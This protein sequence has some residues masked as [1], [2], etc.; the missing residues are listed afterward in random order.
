MNYIQ[1]EEGNVK[2]I[3]STISKLIQNKK[4]NYSK[5]RE[6]LKN[7]PLT[8]NCYD[9]LTDE[10]NG[11]V[12]ELL[13]PI[14]PKGDKIGLLKENS[15]QGQKILIVMLW[16]CELS[17]KENKKLHPYNID[18][19]NAE[20]SKCISNTVSYLGV[21]VKKVLNYIEAINEITK[22]DKNG[23][24]NYYAVWVLCGPNINKLPD[25]SNYPGLVEQFIDCLILYWENGGAVGLFCDNDPLYFQ[26][27]MFLEKVRFKGQNGK[28]EKTKLR[29]TGDDPGKNVLIGYNANGNLTKNSSYDTS[30]IRLPNGTE[31]M[32][33]GRNVP[34]IYEGDSISHA[35]SNNKE[36][37]KPF[38]PF[39]KNSSGNI[40][41]MLYC[42]QGR[43]GDIIIDCGYTKAFFKMSSGDI[44]TWRYF[45]NIA[46]FLSRPEAHM[47]YD[48]GETAKNYRPNG[49]NFKID[50]SNLY[51]KFDEYYGFGSKSTFSILILD[52][53][54]SM[55]SYYGDLIDMTNNIIDNQKKNNKNGIR[56]I[57]FATN[58]KTVNYNL[59]SMSTDDIKNANVGGGT[60]FYKGFQEAAKYI[61]YGKKFDSRRVLFL[62]DGEDDDYYR[63]DDICSTMKYSGYKIYIMGFGAGSLFENLRQFASPDCFDTR[64]VFEDV[65]QICIQAFSS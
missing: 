19:T 30:I 39:A 59:Y 17:E 23:R 2:N 47:I 51:T 26:T 49:I 52:V 34:Q 28:L 1:K 10:Q 43:E 65:K 58:A 24:C 53:S 41:I 6:E 33:L 13:R 3:F 9:M 60:N 29:I 37:I 8:T 4:Y 5:L 7:S 11:G 12:D 14:N 57:F 36:N 64:N 48:D 50:Y 35:N 54:G 62:T 45:Q 21:E 27:N 61:E 31:R 20:N 42:T 38:I 16:S 44:A 25:K 15:L 22:K 32:P 63:I 40:C 55:S 46:G 56:V 18:H